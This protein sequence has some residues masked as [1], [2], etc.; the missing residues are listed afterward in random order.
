MAKRPR[1][2]R[3]ES[4]G[5]FRP[6]GGDNSISRRMQA[7]AGLGETVAGVAEQF[8]R[9]KATELAPEQ[10][11]KD[12]RE[13]AKE[14]EELKKR[15]PLAWG[16]QAYNSVAVATYEAN[17]KVDLD[18]AMLN[19]YKNNP[20]NIEGY[21]KLADAAFEGLTSKAPESVKANVDLFYRQRN[22]KYA[23]PINDETQKNIIANQRG[24]L[25]AGLEVSKDNI[26]NLTR[27]GNEE[28]ALEAKLG[29]FFDL[30]NAVKNGV[31]SP[32]Y[33]EQQ[34]A[35]IDDDVAKQVVL[36]QLDRTIFDESL[37]PEERIQKGEEFISDLI[38]SDI[39]DLNPAQKDALV[40]TVNAKVQSEQI[41][42]NKE[43][44]ALT[45]AEER[46]K[47]DLVR[48]IK[49][50]QISGE[51]A[52]EKIDQ[53]FKDG[54]I[55]NENELIMYE[56]FVISKTKSALKVENDISNVNKVL[57]GERPSEPL[58]QKAVDTYYES[59]QSG[60]P[61]T[62][63][64]RSVYQ[65]QV[66]QST[67]YVPSMLKTELRNDLI[68]GNPEKVLAATD[69]M[70]RILNIAG[71]SEE[72][73]AQELAFADQVIFNMDY[74][75][76]DK[77]I[78]M[79]RT[80]TDQANTA[81]VD[82][83]TKAI[84]DN[85][86]VFEDAYSNE[87]DDAFMGFRED[88]QNNPDAAAQM[89]SD[90]GRLVETYYKAGSSIES[91]KSRAISALQTNWTKSEFGLMKYAPEQFYGKGTDKYLKKDIYDLVKPVYDD[92]GV[93]FTEDD[94][95]LKSDDETARQATQ[96][97]PTYTVLIRTSDGTLQRPMFIDNDGNVA[98]RYKP[99]EELIENAKQAIIDEN[100]EKADEILADRP[101]RQR[102]FQ[103]I[104]KELGVDDTPKE[105]T[106]GRFEGG[107]AE[108]DKKFRTQGLAESLD[109]IGSALDRVTYTPMEMLE[110]VG[111]FVAGKSDEY[112]ESLKKDK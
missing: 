101:Y 34:K 72:F 91:A 105:S 68:S 21:Q 35:A 87:V 48:E 97:K 47:A 2:Q 3:I 65:A 8:G 98:D 95:F 79:A 107:S 40:K 109:I 30:E 36:G 41:A 57:Q 58:D 14:G 18:E 100:K 59:I 63:E 82:A 25:E 5:E 16:A 46:Q 51:E 81:L 88:F 27:N 29:L 64:A 110:D 61:E 83:R 56:G 96:G 6:T 90:Y 70:D 7:L 85:K 92:R 76:A 31:I 38:K 24:D 17:L 23:K 39:P 73:T 54:L 22:S 15:D 53:F 84:K 74:M 108:L 52:Y 106:G 60:L 26:S 42:Y 75:D 32:L 86:K 55:K 43:Q 93:T 71:M 80:N 67:R 89:T 62:P 45:Q 112:I 28:E 33:A 69:T 10:A 50:G 1:Q 20:D 77:A 12:A 37:D 13:A 102:T 111:G 104:A 94:I 66:V 9:A 49:T 44:N 4:Y 78:Q 99:D 11:A 103:K 19:A